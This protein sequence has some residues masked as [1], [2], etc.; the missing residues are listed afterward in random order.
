MTRIRTVGAGPSIE[1]VKV[2]ILVSIRVFIFILLA[3]SSYGFTEQVNKLAIAWNL[4]DQS[5]PAYPKLTT[6]KP[7]LPR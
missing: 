5:L 3:V 1:K 7:N 4:Y 2:P 6:S